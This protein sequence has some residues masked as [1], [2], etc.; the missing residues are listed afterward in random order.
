LQHAAEL[1][2]KERDQRDEK[3]Q[4]DGED[5]ERGGEGDHVHE[6]TGERA[7]ANRF[8]HPCAVRVEGER[9]EDEDPHVLH[10][11]VE[12]GRDPGQPLEE[13][14]ARPLYERGDPGVRAEEKSAVGER[15]ERVEEGGD[16]PMGD[17][18]VGLVLRPGLQDAPELLGRERELE[19]DD[20]R[21]L[22]GVDGA[23]QRLEAAED[24]Q[25]VRGKEDQQPLASAEA[26]QDVG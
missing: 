19:L 22:L 7:R 18:C 5:L 8:Q 11:D 16:P 15:K 20:R 12:P 25:D 13:P 6:G 10:D 17:E 4:R 9:G 3:A 24:D 23:G 2:P 26:V 21:P 14:P 1:R